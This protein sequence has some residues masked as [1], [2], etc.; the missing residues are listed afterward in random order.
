MRTIL[1]AIVV[2]CFYCTNV[3]SQNRSERILEVHKSPLPKEVDNS[4]LSDSSRAFKRVNDKATIS[5]KSDTVKITD[6]ILILKAK[7]ED[8]NP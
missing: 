4:I 7:N 2:I 6:R 3:F 1:L 8:E 5:E